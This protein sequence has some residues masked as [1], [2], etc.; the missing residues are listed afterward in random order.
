[1]AEAEGGWVQGASTRR[2]GALGGLD[3]ASTLLRWPQGSQPSILSSLR[4]PEKH[5]GPSA[6]PPLSLGITLDAISWEEEPL[7]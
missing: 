1:M 5:R 2:P 4:A 6:R 7:P 3:L